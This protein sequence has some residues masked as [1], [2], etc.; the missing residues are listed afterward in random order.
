MGEERERGGG[1]SWRCH[2]K[3]GEEQEE[4]SVRERRGA[5]LAPGLVEW[6]QMLGQQ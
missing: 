6:R 1:F 3:E 4:E 5:K 2:G